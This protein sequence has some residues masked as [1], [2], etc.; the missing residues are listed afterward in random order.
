VSTQL[1]LQSSLT[2]T[3]L[4]QQQF[5]LCNLLEIL[6]QLQGITKLRT[7]AK[8]RKQLSLMCIVENTETGVV[9]V[10]LW[11]GLLVGFNLLDRSWY[12]GGCPCP[13]CRC[14]HLGVLFVR[15]ELGEQKKKNTKF[16]TNPFGEKGNVIVSLE[17]HSLLGASA[18]NIVWY[19]GL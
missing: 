19:Q 5:I 4:C 11:T 15:T 7:C 9:L 16:Q 6:R 13:K 8:M 10:G 3:L 18:V 14:G 17:F 2:F 1:S 12:L